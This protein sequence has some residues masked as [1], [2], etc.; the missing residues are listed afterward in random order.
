MN[1]IQNDEN[2]T[3]GEDMDE[4]TEEVNDNAEK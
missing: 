2:S 3:V 1:L 4:T